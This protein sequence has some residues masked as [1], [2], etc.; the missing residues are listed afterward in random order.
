MK[1]IKTCTL[2]K[3]VFFI[4]NQSFI[5]DGAISKIGIYPFITAVSRYA[6][7]EQFIHL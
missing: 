1:I 7:L 3:E 2:N 4:F 5:T 6:H